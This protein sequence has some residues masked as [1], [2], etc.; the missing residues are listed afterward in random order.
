M[1]V[2]FENSIPIYLQVVEQLKSD[3][4]SG[5]FS[6]G[7]RL[8]S[9]RDLALQLKVN[10]NTV[11]KAFTE[12]EDMGLVFTERTNG[13]FVT[14]DIALIAKHKQEHA[15]IITQKYMKTMEKIGF[16]KSEVI[17]LI[18]NLGGNR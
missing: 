12:L 5:K 15:D 1:A 10:P 9:V 16:D 2:D 17:F 3:I 11:Q 13:K 7:E 18:N 4:I 14:E 6:A 8:P